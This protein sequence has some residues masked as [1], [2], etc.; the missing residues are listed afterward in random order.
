[1][2]HPK[3]I[4]L[5]H[6]PHMKHG[7]LRG[8]ALGR[9]GKG[10]WFQLPDPS[11][12]PARPRASGSFYLHIQATQPKE[13]ST[14][15]PPTFKPIHF[16]PEPHP[17]SLLPSN[18][19]VLLHDV[20]ILSALRGDGRSHRPPPVAPLGGLD[21]APGGTGRE[22][23]GNLGLKFGYLKF[24]FLGINEALD[25]FWGLKMGLECEN[26]ANLSLN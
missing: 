4:S 13:T 1:M 3:K 16:S 18:G 8:L 9:S 17:F 25:V 5:V 22:G 10:G 21:V 2:R 23:S 14:S 19:H 11:L 24:V 6:P 20:R 7:I 26:G 15:N 12:Y